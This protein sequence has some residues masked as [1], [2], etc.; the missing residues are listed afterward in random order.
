MTL[1]QLAPYTLSFLVPFLV[2]LGL[3]RGGAWA[4]GTPLFVFFLLPLLEWWIG[5]AAASAGDDE[6]R[7]RNPAFSWL[8]WLHVPA[9]YVVLLAG[10]RGAAAGGWS[11]LETVG[12][13]LSMGTVSGGI[14]INVA[15]ELI[16]RRSTAEQFLGKALLLS[17]G[18]LHFFIE[19]VRGH[20]KHVA[21]DADP[22]SA[23]PGESFWRFYPR[24]VIGSWRSAWSIEARRLESEHRPV[25]SAGNQMLRFVAATAAFAAGIAAAFGARGAA[26]YAISSVLGFSLLEVVNYIEHY[27]LI[28][29]IDSD[30]RPARVEA[31]HS[32]N[33][34]SRLSRWF[35]FE[36]TRHSDH[37]LHAARQY[38]TLRRLDAAP[39][40]PAGYPAMILL[41]LVP[42][43]WHRVM[44]PI[45]ASI[46]TASPAPPVV[47][48]G[49][50]PS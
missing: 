41:A 18:Y 4:F 31:H 10:C 16:H 23:R 30:G 35:L 50:R 36:L 5:P 1:G 25:W 49:T 29:G 40:L 12:H 45:V 2:A 13:L 48:F 37:H 32:W 24:T 39:E 33:T 3:A 6:Q 14:A 19:H 46:A 43:L 42:P 28:R 15:H 44:D 34:D 22:A 27:G 17:S 8:L 38:Q 20:H 9:Q 7:E 26:F 47:D 11:V 21:T